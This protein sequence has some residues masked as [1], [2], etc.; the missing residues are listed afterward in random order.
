MREHTVMTTN[1]AIRQDMPESVNENEIPDTTPKD[2]ETA[3]P[4]L[5]TEERSTVKTQ[6][7]STFEI[8][9]RKLE[10]IQMQSPAAAPALSVRT[11]LKTLRIQSISD[12][13]DKAPE[14]DDNNKADVLKAE[15]RTH[16]HTQPE[17]A[18]FDQDNEP[19]LML[20]PLNR[21]EFKR[22]LWHKALSWAGAAFSAGWVLYCVVYALAAYGVAGLVSA[23]P[24]QL[25]GLLAAMLAPVALFWMMLSH[26]QRGA[27]INRYAGEL[28]HELQ[29]IIFPSEERAQRVN[30]DIEQLCRQAAELSASSRTV[31]RAITR[32]RQAL[33]AEIR[34]FVGVSKKA[35]FHIDRLAGNINEKSEKLLALTEELEQRTA[36]IGAKTTEGAEA[37]EK[38]TTTIKDRA[39]EMETAL[40]R[41]ADKILEA[42]DKADERT[43]NIESN[44][45]SSYDGLNEAVGRVTERLQTVAGEF[46]KHTQGLSEAVVRVSTETTRLAGTIEEQ[47]KGLEGVTEKTLEAM[48]ESSKTIQDHRQALDLGAQSVT[49]Q[50]EKIAE[51]IN[52]ALDNLGG[53]AS[54]I[55]ER[56][57]GIETRLQTQGDKLRETAT[58]LEKQAE[59]IENAGNSTSNKLTEAMSVALNGAESIS[60]AVRRAI[61]Q[62]EKATL[63]AKEQAESL[64]TSTRENIDQLNSAGEGN[65]EHIRSIVEMLESSREQIE[66]ASKLADEQVTKL[67]ESVETQSTRINLSTAAIIERIDLVQSA[68]SQPLK[69]MSAAVSEADNKHQQIEETLRRR[70]TDLNE[71]SDKARDSAEHIRTILRGQAQ[72]ISTMAGQIAGHSRTI[73][74]QLTQQN[75]ALKNEVTTSLDS[76]GK[77]RDSLEEQTRRLSDISEKAALDVSILDG[78]INVSCLEVS[79]A[80]EKA[81]GD[82]SRLDVDFDVKSTRLKDRA[83]AATD[84]IRTVMNALEESAAGFEPVLTQAMERATEAQAK[85]EALHENY[86][87]SARTNLDRLRE[88]GIVFDERLN[89]LRSGAD[90][91]STILRSSSENLQSRVEDIERAATSA[92]G[93]MREIES[94]LED[95]SSD[96]HLMTDQALI[97]I[98]NVQKAV[99]EQFHEMSESVG[100]AVAR[101]QDVGGALGKSASQIDE[102]AEQ[103]VRRFDQ[104]GARAR[105]ESE[106]LNMAAAKTAEMTN[107]LVA[108]VRDETDTLLRSSKDTLMELK[109]TGDGFE[110]K[111]RE[112]SEQ[113]S[114]ALRT[115][116]NYG[117]ELKRQ[118]LL[119]ADA[120]VDA[121]DQISKVVSDLSSRLDDLDVTSARI[122]GAVGKSRESLAEES[123]RLVTVTSAAV[124]AAD[125]AATSFGRQSNALFKAVQDATYNAEKIRK[126]EGRVQRDAF[127]TSA[128]FIIESMHSLSVDL[129]RMMDGEVPEKTWRAFQKG[130][131]GAFTRRLTQL[132][133]ELPM[134][135]LRTKFANDTEFRT[136]VQRFIRQ[137]EELFEQAVANDHGDLLAATFASSDIGSLYITLCHAAGR[138][139]KLSRENRL[140]A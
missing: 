85:F 29:A 31:I 113:M 98:E 88:I 132:G 76:I 28:R 96:I 2:A 14:E 68:L 40:S 130:D 49:A 112:V 18:T 37:W 7:K 60:S 59:V 110:L 53:A 129:T 56:T 92:S 19:V 136:Y 127:L 6:A 118:A 124:R 80:S 48:S 22:P 15:Q 69:E 46:D 27:D 58:T 43:K 24:I 84:S 135:R 50:A 47:I 93:K 122:A 103:I 128:K 99:N 63:T 26:F 8:T 109:K 10:N 62:L 111:A 91:A 83:D 123:E 75:A 74:D 138:E 5:S 34:D 30:A 13:E 1:S 45:T 44:L 3:A 9:A 67:S 131:V 64:I 41:G 102:T 38:A 17:A 104:A 97:K 140:A 57:E 77:V 70:V 78:K 73:T 117:E 21:P 126:E 12:A 52:N 65:I 121:G 125:E 106:S 94:S 95:Q 42:A 81:I 101:L 139:P 137:F 119:V 20:A 51:T 61:E 87:T 90:Q 100:Q 134:E 107:I 66:T 39:S 32:A 89:A 105:D 86:D 4:V 116:Q 108:K 33:R 72:E 35:E 36:N 71:A 114:A 79:S 55:V 120:S 54:Q 115:S 133:T 23:G 82:L 11:G 25:G 16:A